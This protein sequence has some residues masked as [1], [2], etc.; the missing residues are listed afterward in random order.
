[1]GFGGQ[2]KFKVPRGKPLEENK[3]NNSNELNSRMVSTGT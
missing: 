2:G 1:M 3:N